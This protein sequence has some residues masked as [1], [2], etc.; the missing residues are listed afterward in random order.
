M[1]GSQAQKEE[2]MDEASK[3]LSHRALT[4]VAAVWRMDCRLPRADAGGLL[5]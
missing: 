2:G 4:T 1:S 3:D 5:H